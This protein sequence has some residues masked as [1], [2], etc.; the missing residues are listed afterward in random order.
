[1]ANVSSSQADLLSQVVVDS[2][3]VQRFLSSERGT[4]VTPF[5][6]NL[7]SMSESYSDAAEVLHKGHANDKVQQIQ[8]D[9]VALLAMRAEAECV[10]AT[11][12]TVSSQYSASLQ[13]TDFQQQ[14]R[15]LLEQSM[16]CKQYNVNSDPTFQQFTRKAGANDLAAGSCDEDVML[17]E[18]QEIELNTVCPI[19]AKQTYDL[20]EPVEDEQGVVYERAAILDYLRRNCGT[21][22]CPIAGMSHTITAASLRASKR[23]LREQRR[24]REQR[25]QGEGSYQDSDD[26]DAVDCGSCWA[27]STTGS[28]EGINAIVTGKLTS[29]SEQELI[30]CDTS[31]DH[32]CHGG[33]MDFAFGFIMQNGGLD[34]ERDYKYLAL[35]EAC[36]SKKEHRHIVTIDGYRDVPP[37]D[38]KSLLKVSLTY[39]SVD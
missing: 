9:L 12:D 37:N 38:E 36:N 5:V 22:V 11:L 28:V 14:M 23:I 26:D 24:R 7:S 8:E 2:S 30:D 1:M 31:R 32:G 21:S 27:F 39:A 29:L 35:G 20:D 33:L 4:R 18:G 25:E 6:G 17:E 16:A 3:V 19:T 10:G 34:T 13:A 15:Q